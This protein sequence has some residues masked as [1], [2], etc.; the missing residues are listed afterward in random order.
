MKKKWDFKRISAIGAGAVMALSIAFGM[1]FSDFSKTDSE[2]VDSAN[3][4]ITETVKGGVLI[5]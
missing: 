3:S 1:G 4:E 5:A 2:N